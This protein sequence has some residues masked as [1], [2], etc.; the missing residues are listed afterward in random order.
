MRGEGEGKGGGILL[1]IP[2]RCNLIAWT[3]GMEVAVVEVV[4]VVVAASRC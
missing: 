4:V 1:L 3:R 2:G